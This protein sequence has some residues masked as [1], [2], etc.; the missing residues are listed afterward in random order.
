MEE[1]GQNFGFIHYRTKLS[2]PVLETEL[3]LYDV[4]DRA[5]LFLDGKYLA[6]SK[7]RSSAGHSG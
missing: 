5:L 1:L 2:G 6:T 7:S 4:H 3:H